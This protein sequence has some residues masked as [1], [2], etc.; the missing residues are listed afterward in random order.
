MRRFAYGLKLS[1]RGKIVGHRLQDLD[2]VV[3][4]VMAIEREVKDARGIQEAGAKDKKKEDQSSSSS[5]GK[6]QKISTP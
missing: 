4:M 2:S 1:I 5:S 6:K 3:E